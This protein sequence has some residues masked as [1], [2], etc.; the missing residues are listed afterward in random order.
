MGYSEILA[1]VARSKNIPIQSYAIMRIYLHPDFIT[2][3]N[4]FWNRKH[5]LHILFRD[6]YRFN[7]RKVNNLI[8]IKFIEP[9]TRL[10]WEALT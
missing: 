1:S 2:K 10:V 4:E 5:L 3:I 8:D 6:F 9:Q 7:V